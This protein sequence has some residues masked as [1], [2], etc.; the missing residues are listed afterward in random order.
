MEESKISSKV[1][2]K[3]TN[4]YVKEGDFVSTGQ[5]IL[6]LDR[7]DLNTQFKQAQAGVLVAEAG[8]AKVLAGSRI[9]NIEQAKSALNQAKANLVNAKSNLDR[10]EELYE[11]QVITKQALEGNQTQY[12]VAKETYKTAEQQLKML[13]TG[14]TKE[15]INISRAQVRQ[16]RT[17]MDTAKQQ[18]NNT[19]ITSPFSGVIAQKLVNYG[20]VI[21]PSAPLFILVQMGT[22]KVRVDISETLIRYFST[23]K[24]AKIKLD[25]YPDLNFE[26]TVRNISPV[27]NQQSRTFWVDVFINNPKHLIKPGMF[28]RLTFDIETHPNVLT[29]PLETVFN[30][31]EDK[32]VYIIKNN[33][34]NLSPKLKIGITTNN[35]IE[36]LEGV[37]TGDELVTRGIQNL[38]DKAKVRVIR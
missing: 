22:V 34:A 7:T 21:N 19:T 9:E 23:G 30:K 37:K 35:E 14:A 33:I 24:N 6:T 25:A 1:P 28:A 26:G 2:G 13:T 38:V 18:L 32:Y 10:M 31:G 36:I 29:A 16:A 11:Q 27:I 8:L 4:I 17:A 15:D 5:I 20:E 3:V 12:K